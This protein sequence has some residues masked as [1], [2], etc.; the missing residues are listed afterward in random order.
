MHIVE[1]ILDA[2]RCVGES[3]ES[4]GDTDTYCGISQH[5]ANA[6]LHSP[7]RFQ[8]GLYSDGQNLI[9]KIDIRYF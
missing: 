5:P 9:M 8:T 7:L 4:S 2:T 1:I 6:Y 3:R